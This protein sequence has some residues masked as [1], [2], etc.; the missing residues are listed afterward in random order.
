MKSDPVLVIKWILWP[1]AILTLLQRLI[2]L[3]PNRAKTD[4]FTTVYTAAVRFLR[5]EPVYV[6]NYDTVDPHYLYAPSGSLLMAPFGYFDPE[7]ARNIFVALSTIALLVALYVMLRMFGYG[8]NS[9]VAP[10]VLFFAVMTEAVTNTLVYTNFNLFLLLAEVVA[11]ALLLKRKD[12][13]A[14]VPLGL[15]FAVKPLLAVFLL[16]IILNRQWK[17]LITA[18]SVP[19]VLLGIGWAL[20]A[21]PESYI[22]R[23]M[24]YLGQA[25]DY[26]NSSIS[27]NAAYFGLPD[28]LTLLLKAAVVVMALISV[29]LLYRYYRTSNELLWWSTSAGVLMTAM[30]LVGSLGQGYYSMLLFPMLMTVVFRSSV[31]TNWPAWLAVY[32]FLSYDFWLSG[33]WLALGRSLAYLKCTLGWTLLIVVTFCVLLYRYLDARAEGRLDQGI[34]RPLP[35]GDEPGQHERHEPATVAA[36]TDT[37]DDGPVAPGVARG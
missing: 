22:D 5:H 9:A 7:T 28:W 29:Y 24:P 30:W 17:A 12:L 36:H 4:D 15:S 3:V 19:V 37:G 32:G 21:D 31:M 6:E 14:G 10:A 26:Y 35:P 18:I 20:A 25:R 2:V 8:L 33:K 23:T 11:M 16:L 27:G 13:W 34:D 1:L